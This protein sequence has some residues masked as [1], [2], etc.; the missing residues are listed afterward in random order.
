MKLQEIFTDLPLIHFHGD[1]N[2]EIK[3]ITY[4]SRN[5]HP[6]YLFAALKGI[7]TDG[8]FYVDE[9]KAKGAAA[10]LSERP[11]PGDIHGNW[12]QVADARESMALCAANFFSHPSREMKVVGITGT[13]GKTTVS[14]LLE[15]IFKAAHFQPGLFGTIEYRG[16]GLSE[17]AKRTTPEAPDL[18]RMIRQLRDHGATHCV[19]EIS[20]HSLEMKRAVG[21]DFDAAIFTNL[22]GE[23]LDYHKT[24]DNY[25]EAKKKLFS[26]N[27]KSIAVINVDD[28]WGK[29]L[30][31][32]LPMEKIS[33]GLE[34]DAMIRAE[35]FSFNPDGTE[36][37]VKIPAGHLSIS[38]PLLG[39]P[40]LYNILSALTAAL[41]LNVP[42]SAIKKGISTVKTVPGRFE[43]IANPFGLHIFV[44][45]A[46]T[47]DALRNLLE[48]AR[49]LSSG[50]VLLIFGAGGDKDKSKRPRMGEFAGKLADWTILTSDNPRS[51]E[52]LAIITDIE[53]GIKKTGPQKY[54]IQPDR[55]KAIREI[56]SMGKKDD[57]ILIAG[58][59]HEDYQVIKDKIIHFDDAEVVREL[60][61]DMEN[62]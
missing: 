9:A 22:S 44:D 6:G 60:L 20:S 40:N 48:T 15:G 55:K 2:A 45:F 17:T 31:E 34:P 46:H 21:I 3:E 57:Y 53:L 24:M 5:V 16:P 12:I 7:K 43:K 28:T 1:A 36:A 19:M 25:F 30:F 41:S 51:E 26:L 13:K 35:T 14:Y 29:K 32:K 8:F 33:Y 4:S 23:H 38:S 49:R 39:K 56:L 50:R 61:A 54:T 62:I 59:G 37:T 27:P 52:P 47:D 18:Q 11:K 42:H 58:K 10:I